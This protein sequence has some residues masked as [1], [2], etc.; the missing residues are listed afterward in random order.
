M[1][2]LQN[3]RQSGLIGFFARTKLV[4]RMKR[5]TH[6]SHENVASLGAADS[7]ASRSD[8]ADHDGADL[9]GSAEMRGEARAQAIAAGPALGATT[10]VPQVLNSHIPQPAKHL[11]AAVAIQIGTNTRINSVRGRFIKLLLCITR[12]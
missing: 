7:A 12:I 8:N 1:E 11:S 5:T 3:A 9:T 10:S 2:E 6:S 4:T